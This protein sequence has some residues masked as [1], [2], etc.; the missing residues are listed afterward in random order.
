MRRHK[1]DW[2]RLAV[3][4]GSI[5]PLVVLITNYTTERLSVN[6]IQDVER[7]TG[8]TALML[9]V[10]SLACTPANTVFGFKRALSV[11]RALG[12]YAFY[13]AALHFLTFAVLDFG[14]DTALIQDEI[15][16]KRYQLIGL[17]AL[18]IMLP[19]AV[20]ST[21]TW[22]KRL[23]RRWRLLHR[24]VYLAALLA[25]VH[26]VWLVK[27]DIGEPLRFGA[28]VVILLTLR[29]PA[30]RRAVSQLRVR[31]VGAMRNVRARRVS[32]KPPSGEAVQEV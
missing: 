20:T 25:V 11:R 15:I 29:V 10:V 18:I 24:L 19:M 7:I 6:P 2:L 26:F 12:L 3:H 31:A 4:A 5:A 23:G 13:Y 16:Q 9:L 22:Q 14:L 27:S 8:H 17:L 28:V 1:I 21:K 30:V 32:R